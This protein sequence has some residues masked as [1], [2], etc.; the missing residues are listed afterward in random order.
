MGLTE[1]QLSMAGL[2]LWLAR[3]QGGCCL[4][5]GGTPSPVLPGSP[6][7]YQLAG[8]SPVAAFSLVCTRPNRPSRSL[9]VDLRV[10][11]LRT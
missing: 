5:H 1:G 6:S 7:S 8:S 2:L 3:R 10:A 4:F 9:A 11:R